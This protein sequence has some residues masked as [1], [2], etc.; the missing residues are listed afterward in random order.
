ME[1]QTTFEAIRNYYGKVL[2]GKKDLK[3]NACCGT[4]SFPAHLR[5]I[6]K[7]IH[8]EII[9]KCYGC[10]SPIP[11][12]L[13]GL[14]VL[15]LGCG[16]G[17]DS[18]ILSKLVGPQ[19]EVIGVDMTDE[20]LEVA[21]RHLRSPNLRFLK[22]YIEDLESLG[23]KNNSVDLI[24]SNCV[25]NLSP[26]KRR[27]FSE[28]FRVLK[29]GG[30][31]YFADIF[32]GRRMPMELAEDPVLLGE[33]LGGALYLEDFRRLLVEVGCSDYRVISRSRIELKNPE[34]EARA[35]RID[36]WS[37]AIRAFKLKL[38]D[39]CEDYGQIA[40]YLGTI[41]ES[42]HSLLLDD[43]HLFEKGRPVP[44]CS[45]TAAMLQRTR[46]APHFRVTGDLSIHY[47]LFDCGGSSEAERGKIAS[48]GC[49]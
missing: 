22:G 45:N 31:L 20:Q 16:T 46:Y 21:R 48:G 9:E 32:T 49:C 7:T 36:F 40:T 1:S 27:V 39:R 41:P 4:D 25:I 44:I 8:P 38:E 14:T 24:V 30:E 6:V 12:A 10:G 17:R 28:I 11:S 43:H 15:D 34:V 2:T 42:P 37:M 18:Y 29:P 5:E 19:G 23:I 3:T 47:G 35:G 33:C 13:E 26:D